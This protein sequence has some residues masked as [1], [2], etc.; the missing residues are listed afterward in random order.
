[1]E[2]LPSPNADVA[3]IRAKWIE[4][5]RLETAYYRAY[6][7]FLASTLRTGSE[8]KAKLASVEAIKAK[9]MG[10]N[11]AAGEETSALTEKLGGEAVVKGRMNKARLEEIKARER[12]AAGLSK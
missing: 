8:D 4:A 1:M 9:F 6:A 7:A 3:P 10:I 5:A 12:E 2:A 11:D